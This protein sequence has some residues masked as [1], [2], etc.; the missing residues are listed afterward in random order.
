VAEQAQSSAV[1]SGPFRKVVY[2][3]E[4]E[5]TA[6]GPFW[7]LVLHSGHHVMRPRHVTTIAT[8]FHP[9]SRKLA[10]KRTRCHYCGTG[11][12]THDPAETV[13]MLGGPQ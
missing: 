5:G 10:P 12:E 8:L 1:D 9:M 11:A 6:G 13:R 7:L 2:I 3:F 4:R